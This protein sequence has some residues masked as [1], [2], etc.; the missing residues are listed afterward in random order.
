MSHIET[1]YA[2]WATLLLL[3][4]IHLVTNYFAVRAVTLETL[5]R[6]RATILFTTMLDEHT[7][8][9]PRQVADRERVF[10][11]GS[12]V[13]DKFGKCIGT[14][15]LGVSLERLIKQASST[16]SKT[17]FKSIDSSFE[18][19]LTTFQNERYVMTHNERQKH[20]CVVFKQHAAAQ[21]QMQA[22]LHGMITL[23]AGDYSSRHKDVPKLTATLQVAKKL[24]IHHA[25]AMRAKGWNLEVVPLETTAG[26]RLNGL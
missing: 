1:T 19:I 21:D 15:S 23:R 16:R 18:T 22:W 2:T 17:A 26:F 14:I 9:S 4:A 24:L 12:S 20:V 6:Q 7:V 3:L 5:N 13:S 11:A 8:L 10:A 25:P